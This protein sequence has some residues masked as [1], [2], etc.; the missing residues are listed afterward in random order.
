MINS[1]IYKNL[2]S[3]A[4]SRR[5]Y[6][7]HATHCLILTPS[8]SQ[9]S[10]D[11]YLKPCLMHMEFIALITENIC[12]CCSWSLKVNSLINIHKGRP[13]TSTTD[14]SIPAVLNR[15]ARK[16]PSCKGIWVEIKKIILKRQKSQMCQQLTLKTRWPWKSSGLVN[17]GC[18]AASLRLY[19]KWNRTKAM[20]EHVRNL[21][22]LDWPLF[23]LQGSW[24]LACTLW[25]KP[26]RKNLLAHKLAEMG[27]LDTPLQYSAK[28]NWVRIFNT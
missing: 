16:A 8:S 7:T 14:T 17:T 12:I 13:S 9:V 25:N 18:K 11:F 6:A 23:Q 19:L 15:L 22:L 27:R 21:F 1:H 24:V 28:W 10:T 4:L 3:W 5:M 2:Y 20:K 26:K